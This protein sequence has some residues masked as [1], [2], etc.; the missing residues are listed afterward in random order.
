MNPDGYRHF[1]LEDHH[2]PPAMLSRQPQLNTS[3]CPP[4]PLLHQILF[5]QMIGSTGTHPVSYHL[6]ICGQLLRFRGAM[7]LRRKHRRPF[8]VRIHTN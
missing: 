6:H 2:L 8:L 3:L 7:M 5:A 4:P 1:A